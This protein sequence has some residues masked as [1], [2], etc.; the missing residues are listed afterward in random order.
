MDA[1]SLPKVLQN[2][3]FNIVL[4]KGGASLPDRCILERFDLNK[5]EKDN[6]VK[7][8]WSVGFGYSW[9]GHTPGVGGEDIV[10]AEYFINLDKSGLVTYILS[11]HKDFAT[12]DEI[13]YN[14]EIQNLFELLELDN[15]K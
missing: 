14:R 9:P 10:P 11:K 5:K 15:E 4:K 2:M 12:Y 6:V 13:Y 1:I 8:Y 7:V 3:S